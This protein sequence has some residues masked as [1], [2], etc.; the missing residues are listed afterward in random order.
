MQRLEVSGAVR[1]IYGSLGV[2]W[3][4]VYRR[5]FQKRPNFC[6]GLYCSFYSILW[7]VPFKVFPSTGDIPFPT[8]LPFLERFLER[9][10]CDGARFSYCIFLNLLYD[11]EK[12]LLSKRF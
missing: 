2:K 10:F 8:F 3:L 6:Y 11:L 5:W 12:N 7:A 4:S 1:P 9:T